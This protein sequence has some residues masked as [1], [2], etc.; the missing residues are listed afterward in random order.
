MAVQILFVICVCV[1]GGTIETQA[2]ARQASTSRQPQSS[3]GLEVE[4]EESNERGVLQFAIRRRAEDG[5]GRNQ[6]GARGGLGKTGT[7]RGHTGRFCGGEDSQ[8]ILQTGGGESHDALTINSKCRVRRGYFFPLINMMSIGLPKPHPANFVQSLLCFFFSLF[9]FNMESA[10]PA[11]Q[12]IQHK[13]KPEQGCT[14]YTSR[15]LGCWP[16]AGHSTRRSWL[17]QLWP[18]GGAHGRYVLPPVCPSPS[19]GGPAVETRNLV[20]HLWLC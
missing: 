2:V 14:V 12:K 15:C 8:E 20:S 1:W 5:R 4:R 6:A 3:L 11:P 19:S 10:N 13:K 7:G 18:G 9:L 16:G 17:P